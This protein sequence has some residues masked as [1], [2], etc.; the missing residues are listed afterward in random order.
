[1]PD[2][3]IPVMVGTGRRGG[4]S[5]GVGRFVQE[6]GV[7]RPG[8][9]APLLLSEEVPNAPYSDG[10]PEG[11]L[12]PPEHR[13]FAEAI[14]RADGY[15]I[16]TPEYNFGIPGSLKSALDSV[17]QEWAR[18]PFALVGVSSGSVGGARALEQ[19]RSVVGG[20]KGVTVPYQV[21]VRDVT[22]TFSDQGPLRDPGEV[23]NKV[24]RLW[25]EVE[26][27]ARALRDA[28]PLAPK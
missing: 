1:M 10:D 7:R 5:L 6:R 8:V 9:S 17:Y 15:V 13:A 22:A 4:R 2:L 18:K 27:Y 21:L 24:D 16:V 3:E 26:W 25:A 14:G 20:V 19:L 28:R 12:R 11:S 23:S